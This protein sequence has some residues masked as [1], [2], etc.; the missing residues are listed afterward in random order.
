VDCGAG[1][2]GGSAWG[3]VVED[4]GV[5]AYSCAGAEADWAE[6]AG[7]Y[8]DGDVVFEDRFAGV[9]ALADGDVVEQG[10]VG[11]EYRST[12][13]GDAASGVV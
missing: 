2:D 9:V 10:D 1:S 13:D 4:D 7:A 6:D 3:Y 8:A 12:V 11:A 5:G